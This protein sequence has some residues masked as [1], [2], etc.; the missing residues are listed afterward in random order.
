MIPWSD[1]Q[2]DASY[3]PRIADWDAKFS[4][5]E[6][7]YT[8]KEI[9]GGT[10]GEIK[11]KELL[12]KKLK[13]EGSSMTA[14]RAYQLVKRDRMKAPVQ[15]NIQKTNEM[16][17]PFIKKDYR[18]LDNYFKQFAK[19]MATESEFGSDL[20]KL[21]KAIAK[22]PNKQ[23]R[24]DVENMFG[25]MFT[26]QNWDTDLGQVYN[27]LAAM[28]TATKMTFS[29]TK[30]LFHA[31]N[32]PLVMGGRVMPIVKGLMHTIGS[33]KEVDAQRLLLWHGDAGREP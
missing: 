3:M 1:F 30:V 4:D 27:A 33:P 10:F 9:M 15:G 22:I 5:G 26:P 13:E 17:F 18:A 32:A 24:T 25:Y 16:N 31:A 19:A 7:T 14:E 20:R 11:A 12:A 29:A 2:D 28:E 23:A 6:K 21:Q 8:L